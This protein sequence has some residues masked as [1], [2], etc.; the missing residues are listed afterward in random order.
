M[1]ICDKTIAIIGLGGLGGFVCEYASR[2]GFKKIILI[3]GDKFSTSNMNRQLLCTNNTLDTYKVD[4][5]KEK[6]SSI[7]DTEVI[8]IKEFLT[9]DNLSYIN[10]CDLIFDCLDN[11]ESRLLVEKAC[12]QNNTPIIHGAI[13]E[14]FGNICISLPKSKTLERLYKGQTDTKL[15][16]QAHSVSLI[17]SL[18]MELALKYFN[19]NYQEY[20]NKIIYVDLEDFNFKVLPL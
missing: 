7:S 20:I 2:L 16:T 9:K 14:N 6:I 15:I 4:N 8:A 1:S 12:E 10:N 5:Y 17:A 19:D 18:Q 13:G 3:D 11:I